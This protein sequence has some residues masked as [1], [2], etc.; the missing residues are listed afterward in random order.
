MTNDYRE[1]DKEL[2]R[3]GAL[4][5]WRFGDGEMIG[6]FSNLKFWLPANFQTG[7]RAIA[8]QVAPKQWRYL[9]PDEL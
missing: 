1:T 6:R 2:P 3:D 4:I 8:L 7:K 5:A 9:K